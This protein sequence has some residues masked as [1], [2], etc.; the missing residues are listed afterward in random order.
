MKKRIFI[1]MTVLLLVLSLTTSAFAFYGD[2]YVVTANGKS[3]NL[4]SFPKTETNNK[5]ANIPFGEKVWV[6]SSINEGEWCYV[7]YRGMEGYVVS[8]YLSYNKPSEKPVPAPTYK[9]TPS[10]KTDYAGF[11]TV[12]LYSMV[13]PSTPGGYVHMR[14]APTKASPVYRDYYAGESLH[15]IA[16]NNVW[17]QV[18]DVA[19][20]RVGFMMN[21]FLVPDAGST[22]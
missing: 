3:L 1:T 20:G 16:R 22:Y 10:E 18:Q 4:R 12:D 15:V 11:V 13:R 2:M 21:H 19:T 5:I 7:N 6:E 8:R 17:S 9:P 14:W